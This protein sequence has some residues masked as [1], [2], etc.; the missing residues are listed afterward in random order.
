MRF[1]E[2]YGRAIDVVKE[3]EKVSK[4]F[5]RKI[6]CMYVIWRD[7][8]VIYVGSSE[9]CLERLKRHFVYKNPSGSVFVKHWLKHFGS[10]SGIEDCFVIVFIYDNVLEAREE[11]VRA[12]R[13]LK[14]LFNI[15]FN[16][17]K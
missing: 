5:M 14:P 2:I 17:H 6:P 7:S 15:K 12:I 10:L 11:E 16:R 1:L 4:T 3:L 13:V 9:D 8:D